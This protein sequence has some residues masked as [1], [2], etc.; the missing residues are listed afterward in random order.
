MLWYKH[1]FLHLHLVED[2]VS[3]NC[4]AQGHKLIRHE[5]VILS[6]YQGVL[7]PGW[8]TYSSLCWFFLSIA[9]ASVKMPMYV[10]V[11]T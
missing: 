4:L 8:G 7:D 11:S 3:F 5:T 9:K 6:V 2:I 1:N 10:Y